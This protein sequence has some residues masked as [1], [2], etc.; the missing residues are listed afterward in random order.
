MTLTVSPKRRAAIAAQVEQAVLTTPV[1]DIHTHL[2]DPAFGELL[3]WGID[4][5]LVY[6]YLVAEAFR[7]FDLPYEKFWAMSKTE[8]ADAIWNALF[9]EHSPI[10][11]SCRG[12][13]TTLN[14]LGL[15]VRKRDLPALRKWFAKWKVADYTTH[16]MERAGVNRICM[17]NS[18]FDDV[19]RVVWE[20]GFERDSRFT[21]ALRIDPLLLS[22]NDTAAPRLR[23]WG[24]AV[25][26]ELCEKT[27][28]EVRRFLAD[29]T[30]RIDAQYLMVSL[31]PDFTYPGGNACARLMETAVLPHCREFG[32]PFAMMPGVKRGV[33]PLLK[34]AGDGV[35]LCD[36][37]SYE[38]LISA[39]PDNQFLITA[40]ARE[41]QYSLCVA[42]RKFRNLHLFGCW[43]FTNIP[44]LIE[45]MTR[46]RLELI[47]LS[48]TPQHS[49]ARVLD[50]I[51]YKWDHSRRIIAR[52]LGEKYDDLTATGWEPTHAEIQRD[53]QDLLGGAF[54]RF[55]SRH[56]VREAQVRK[57]LAADRKRRAA[58]AR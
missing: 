9:V 25:T 41:N 1:Y 21:A 20:R 5:L 46:M 31:P 40:L 49:D 7:Q 16:V 26:P 29:W 50:Q 44:Y 43:W 30:R 15:D 57:P 24:Y 4:D 34:L 58:K 51:L 2:Y 55:C 53:V 22:W 35:G 47:G 6:H 32:L 18:P 12:V 13:L 37:A 33:N 42:A 56:Q 17:T 23:D 27:V 39:H 48:V 11:E 36:T 8:Q 38:S 14:R 28:S 54:E 10:S 3:L 19:E 45:E 52:V